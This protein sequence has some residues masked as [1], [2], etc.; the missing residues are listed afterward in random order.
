MNVNSISNRILHER[1]LE[2]GQKICSLQLPSIWAE[3]A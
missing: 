3:N 1:L 2:V